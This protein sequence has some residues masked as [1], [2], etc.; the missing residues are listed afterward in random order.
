VLAFPFDLQYSLLLAMIVT[1]KQVTLSMIVTI[2][3]GF[4]L[5]HPDFDPLGVVYL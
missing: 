4:T 1:I 5:K 2:V 3:A